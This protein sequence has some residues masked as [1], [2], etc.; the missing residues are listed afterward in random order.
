MDLDAAQKR[1]LYLEEQRAEVNAGQ[2]QPLRSTSLSPVRRELK[3]GNVRI[4]RQVEKD[5][6]CKACVLM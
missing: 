3:A 1:V 6:A 5:Q 2:M 4:G